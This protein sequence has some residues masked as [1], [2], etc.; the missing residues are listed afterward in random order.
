LDEWT[1]FLKTNGVVVPTGNNNGSVVTFVLDAYNTQPQYLHLQNSSYSSALQNAAVMGGGK[2]F[3]VGS[4]SAISNA[5]STIFS[6]IQAVNSTFASASL[7]VNTTNRTQDR[8]QVF[9]PMF[10]PDPQ[11]NPRWMG[12]LK[13]FQLIALDGSIDLGGTNTSFN[14]VNPLTGFV[15]PCAESFWTTDSNRYWKN[16]ASDLPVPKGLCPNSV[17]GFSSWSD[18]P[19]GPIV[20]KGGIGEVI[21]KG[22]NPSATN[23]SPTW[24]VNRT[25]YTLSSLNTLAPFTSTTLG[26]APTQVAMANF[27]LGHDVGNV[28][29]TG[30]THG[31]A[32]IDGIAA[33]S[34][35]GLSLGLQVSAADGSVATGTFIT[36]IGTNSITLNAASTSGQGSAFSPDPVTLDENEASALIAFVRMFATAKPEHLSHGRLARWATAPQEHLRALQDLRRSALTTTGNRQA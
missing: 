25:V 21:R 10:R 17:T 5:L 28:Q 1:Y 31:T 9:I 20:E 22:N 32:T 23:T 3:A 11:D 12:N 2:Y 26:S 4:A 34:T 15:D 19:D 36:A 14:A 29:F 27:I 35:A 30:N 6:E 24:T 13:Q 7:P 33:G 8:N 16:D 18:D